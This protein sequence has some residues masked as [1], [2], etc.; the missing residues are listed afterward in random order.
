M[1]F[2]AML[3]TAQ[4]K[5]INV[6]FKNHFHTKLF[7]FVAPAYFLKNITAVEKFAFTLYFKVLFEYH[8]NLLKNSNQK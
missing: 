1:N 4:R 2:S 3:S 8:I 7:V 5:F 6:H